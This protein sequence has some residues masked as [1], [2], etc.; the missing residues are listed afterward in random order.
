MNGSHDLTILGGD[1]FRL[2]RIIGKLSFWLQ[3]DPDSDYARSSIGRL[4]AVGREL[5]AS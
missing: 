2:E 5:A 1:I 3:V 4:R